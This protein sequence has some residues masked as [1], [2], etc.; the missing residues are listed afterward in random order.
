MTEKNRIWRRMLSMLLLLSFILS[1][2]PVGVWA[3]ED[4]AVS[5][6]AISPG[7]PVLDTELTHIICYGQSFSTGSDAPYYPD[8]TV[9]NVY[10]YGG[11][12]N[13]ANG[14]ELQ[15]LSGSAANQHPII[16]AGNVFAKL[17]SGA[18]IDTDIVLG[19]YGSGGKTIAQLMSAQRQAEI[20]EEEGYTY[21]ILSSGRYTVFRNSV[22]AL[23]Q[24]AQNSNKSI[25]CP[26]I[27][28]LQGETD[29]NT[30][31]QLGYPDN[32]ARAGYG[33]GGDKEKYKE[34]MSRLKEDM[35]REVM[36][37][38][39]QTEKPLFF[40]YQVSGTYTRT[41]YSSINMAQIEFAQE[42]DDVIL[43]QTPYFTSHY[44]NSH[45]LTQNGYRWLGEYIGRSMYTALVE[46]EKPWPM[47]PQ[48]IELVDGNLVRITVSGAQGG[49]TID[50][51]TV[52]NAS[53]SKNL[54]GFYLQADG[55]TIVPTNVSVSGNS[56]ELTLPGYL[57]AETVFVYYA[58]RHASGT[59]NV[60]DNSTE[61]GFYEYLDDSNDTGTGN[62][63]GVS[64]SAEDANGNSIIGQ[65]YPMYHWLASFC[66]EIQV[67]EAAK[68][69]ATVYQWEMQEDGLVSVT[70]GNA[71]Q[72]N[73]TLLQ[74][75]VEDGVLTGARYTM[76]KAIVLEHDRLWAIEWK[77]AGNGNSFGGGKL[78]SSSGGHDSGAQYLYLPAD[79]R[80]MVAW[81]VGSHSANFGFKLASFGIDAREEHVYR[82][83]NRI[84]DDGTNN[85]Y[86]IVDD[87]EIGPMTTGYRTSSNTSG[88][89]GSVIDEPSNWVN[90]KNIYLD[91]I[92]EGGSFLLKNLKLSYLK[93]WEDDPSH[94]HTYESVVTAP[95]CTKK[96]Y[97]VYTCTC[98]DSYRT[99]WL[100][101]GAYEGKTIACV[102]DSITAGVGV[103]KDENDYVKLLADQLGMEYIRL[104]ASGTT[105]C[106]D[107]SRT[108]CIGNLTESKL[109]G[110]DVV[111][112]ALGINDFCAAGTGYYELG[113][114]HSTDS[115]TIYGAARMWCER[116]EELRKTDSL[117]DT[118]FY[119]L[120]PVIASWNN[121]VTSV[122][123]WDQSK[124]NIH[125]Y[126]LRDLCN[127]IIE[128]AAMYDVAVIDLNLLSGMYYVDAQ[129][130]NTAVFGGD[131][132]HPGANGHAMMASAIADVLLQNNL[133]DD[134]THTYGSW[135]TTTWPSCAN[136]EQQRV[137]TICSAT[138]SRETEP[139]AD[140]IY[141]NGT[142]SRCGLKA[143]TY[144]QQLPE[145]IS[146]CSNLYDIL[147]PVKGYYTATKY[148]T[149]NGAVLSVVIP[150]EPGDRIAASSFASA[151]E[152]MGS[153]NGIRVTYLMGDQIVTS[154][155]AGDVYDAYTK[156]GYITVPE[157]VDAVCI[158]WWVPSDSN[159]L[160]LGQLS[161]N[162]ATH[163]PQS[164]PVQ[165]PTCTE[166]GYTAGEICEICG[167]SLGTRTQIP[168]T[169]HSYSENTCT[170]CG[171]ANVLAILDGKYVS[172]LGDSI[173][174]FNGYSNDATVN[175][176][177]G[178]NEPRYDV[179]TADTKPG[180]YCLLESV[181][182]TW[183]MRF[184]KRNGMDLLVNNSWAGSQ[185]F[186]GQTSDG[187]I[188]PAAYLDRC[189]NL[190]DNTI[191]NNPGNTP[192]CPDV[193]FIYLGIND[194]NFNRSNVGSGAVD[195][196]MLVGSD[197]TYV[198][199]TTFGEAYGIMLHKMLCAYPNA[200]IFAMTLLP[201]NLYS[202]NKEVW[203]QHNAYIRAAAEYYGIPV[204]D[205][206]KNCT[207]TW[208][209]YS[210]FMIDKIH[211]TTAGME[212]ISNC[213]E[214]ELVAY[215]TE[216]P[217][218]T[219][220]YTSV[221]TVP[222]CT[223][224]GYTTYTCACGYSYV[225]DEVEATGHK[226]EAVV[227][228][229]TCA[230][231]GYTTHACVCGHSY[232]SDYLDARGY[233]WMLEDGAFKILLI[234]NS[235]SEDASNA[236]MPNSQ[237][238]DT[239]QAM[240]GEDVSVTVG[241]CYSGGKGL[242]WHAT[243]SEQGNKSYSLRVISTENGSW[244]SLGS[245]TSAD[246]LTWTN[247][248]VVSL[249]HYEINTSNGKESNAYPDQVDP[250][251]DQLKP[252]AEFMLDYVDQYAPNAAVYFYMHWART[253]KP[254]LN[255][256][257]ATYNK[258]AA[259]F[260]EVLDYAGTESANRFETIIPVGLSVQNARTTYLAT[261]AY[262]TTAYA[263]KTL[264]LYTDAQ[265][266][267]LRDTGHLSYN[268]GRYIAAL[269]F[270]ETI[271]PDELRAD[272]YVLPDIRVTES[273]GKLPKEYTTIAQK[274]VLAAVESWKQG[275]LAVT[276]IEGYTEDPTVAAGATLSAADLH[277]T[278][279]AGSEEIAAAVLAGLPADFAVDSV[280]L[281]QE[282]ALKLGDTFTCRVTIRFGYTSLTVTAK[283]SA[284]EHRY[285]TV[286]TAP[287]CTE[288]G[289]T[290]YICACGDSYADSYVEATG[291]KYETVVTAPTCTEGG[292]TT[293]TC[294]NCNHSY[295]GDEV[296]A[297]G[298]KYE[299]VVTAPTCTEKGYTTHRCLVCHYSYVDTFVDP[300]EHTPKDAAKENETKTG[301]D[302]VVYCADCGK[303]LSREYVQTHIPGDINGDGTINSRDATRLF[304]YLA[305]WNVEVDENALD[306][307][308]DGRVNNRDA[309]LL[310]QYLAGWKVEIH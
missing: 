146:G 310:F 206:A 193:I 235:F 65:K 28:Y 159:W 35:Q 20:K 175:T 126:T 139:D 259:F 89:A 241:L 38:Y 302:L 168:A 173:S 293:Y 108:C 6:N 94:T 242:N 151:S 255:E 95:I 40:I 214:A 265:I 7:W 118:Q 137:C 49:L 99:P 97:T 72:N 74:G 248:D 298:H 309:T 158:P 47:L 63:Q 179:G 278:C 130:N 198:T 167:D 29:Q 216:N 75:S 243:Q 289:Y 275:S 208:E 54:Y 277:V 183:W 153:V 212:L 205:L 272:G 288:Q 36:E 90:G 178:G 109:K 187:R 41:Q 104:G 156:N 182:D 27:V 202:V 122:R 115:S 210:D 213:I 117:S 188:I 262:N 150:V 1:Y 101:E 80:S 42:N 303:E 147:T 149:G 79:S 236:G 254:N 194:Y 43:V 53:N 70:E 157:G 203:E 55:Q 300:V 141:V 102:G 291:H 287:T 114:I 163:S 105:L 128:V 125:G 304:Q 174:T 71:T 196:S 61:L 113:D 223:E 237:M 66:Y 184:A 186:G 250:K 160:T 133:R 52:E 142:C 263:D 220:T 14:T 48:S 106:T 260:P 59:G 21:D 111:T 51:W 258:M 64:H 132:V 86:L 246:A 172:V 34:Y 299:T 140:H 82:I 165:S 177:I 26:A 201:E 32:P 87:V 138:E 217:P 136:G 191:E 25:S 83:E 211:P 251:F 46:R 296:A 166:V 123:D 281:N 264:N 91:C 103:T 155:S 116:I 176:T 224:G 45:H 154:V 60:R 69:R 161:K 100:D 4:T 199:P 195:Y 270:A 232:S 218:H 44:T 227:T 230:E 301:Y 144:L 297:T 307:N 204:V 30:D 274:S 143:S 240:L 92:G 119:F 207:I 112:I 15:H 306:V 11:I 129:D 247:W 121:S 294:T 283:G 81:G 37:A 239:L 120:T 169:G 135:I 279:G 5:E 84:A 271:I 219:H 162:F 73:L 17:L 13:S 127:A 58:G 268:I 257:L 233:D 276:E 185:V 290:T 8:A 244:K 231:Q 180:S 12:T 295:V 76:E 253:Y 280:I 131:G 222:T 308:G 88:A 249:Q 39:G 192:I 282:H 62:N 215:Y 221:V 96:G 24:Y 164:V 238:L 22:S 67:P 267:L 107:G 124:T 226:Y 57:T 85:V 266:G 200:Q 23:S 110:A 209:N 68:R 77:S 98:G 152:N 197:G 190:H 2:V 171:T 292:Y 234:G 148:D 10:V 285:E 56:I 286:V 181:D 245:Y 93:V 19:S 50:T 305:G 170:I 3:V 228:V 134:H 284:V 9:D 145:N 256:S 269:T 261:L 18:G 225:G 189:V 78:L 31:A 33:A 252:A 229:P 16:S 273:V